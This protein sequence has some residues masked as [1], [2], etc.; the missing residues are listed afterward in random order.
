M[1]GADKFCLLVY[2][3]ETSTDGPSHHH[4]PVPT[5]VRMREGAAIFRSFAFLKPSLIGYQFTV[6]L[7]TSQNAKWVMG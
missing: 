2:C 5:L 1:S 7:E 3:S 6:L 4:C